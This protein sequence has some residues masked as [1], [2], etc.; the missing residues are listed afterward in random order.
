LAIARSVVQ[1]SVGAQPEN[2]HVR[3]DYSDT[4][5]AEKCWVKY[6]VLRKADPEQLTI[7][8]FKNLTT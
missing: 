5:L 4:L 6:P 3:G 1:P 2:G 7:E 8:E